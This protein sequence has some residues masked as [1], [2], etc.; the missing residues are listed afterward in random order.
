MPVLALRISST[1][2]SGPRRRTSCGISDITYV[3]TWS[4]FAYA[5]LVTDVFFRRIVGWRVSNT[6]RT[7][8]AL[9][10]LEELLRSAPR[11]GVATTG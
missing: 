10:A 4:G 6:L 9:E 1:A 7:D 3:A 11:G 8:L 5:A 2:S